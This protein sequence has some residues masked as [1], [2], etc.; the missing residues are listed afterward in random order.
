M[1]L[2]PLDEF[3]RKLW[4]NLTV[5][6]AR[7]IQPANLAAPDPGRTAGNCDRRIAAVSGGSCDGNPVFGRTRCC[8]HRRLPG[9]TIAGARRAGAARRFRY[10][11]KIRANAMTRQALEARALAWCRCGW[12]RTGLRVAVRHRDGPERAKLAVVTPTHHCPTG[13]ALSLPRRM[14]LLAWAGETGAW[15]AGRPDYDS[16]FRYVGRPLPSLKSLDRGQR[17]LYVGHVQQGAVSGAAA[18][19]PRGAAGTGRIVPAGRRG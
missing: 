4:S 18:G 9:C 10:G 17:V 7:S 1:G 19:I 14:E 6:A 2:R 5:Q 12:I 15:G 11:W 13:V 8:D 16:E 3:P